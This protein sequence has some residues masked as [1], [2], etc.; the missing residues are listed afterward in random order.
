MLSKQTNAMN[1]CENGR[2]CSNE[3]KRLQ[4]R[5]T[6]HLIDKEM[7]FKP[8]PHPNVLPASTLPIY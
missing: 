2:Y 6:R 3:R 8:R 4:A 7:R 5:N 1:E